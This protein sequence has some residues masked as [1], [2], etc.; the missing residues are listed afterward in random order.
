MTYEITN[1]ELEQFMKK[2]F[3]EIVDE[4]VGYIDEHLI[5]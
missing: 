3:D 4:V 5:G 2:F 1:E